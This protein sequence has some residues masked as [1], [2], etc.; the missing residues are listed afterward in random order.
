MT[1]QDKGNVHVFISKQKP[2]SGADGSQVI[3]GFIGANDTCSG[4]LVT[5]FKKVVPCF[6]ENKN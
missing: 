1:F 2:W 6:P 4:Y 5:L 3:Y